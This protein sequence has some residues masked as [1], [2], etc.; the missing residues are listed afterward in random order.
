MNRLPPVGGVQRILVTKPGA[1]LFN[2]WT[3]EEAGRFRTEAVAV[4]RKHGVQGT[5]LDNKVATAD[6]DRVRQKGGWAEL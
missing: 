1:G 5:I 4:L 6:L 3:P 2:G